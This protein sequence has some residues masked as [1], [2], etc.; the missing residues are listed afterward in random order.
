MNP[1]AC[2][3][4]SRNDKHLTTELQRAGD[5]LDQQ[6]TRAL[7]QLDPSVLRTRLEPNMEDLNPS[8]Q[9]HKHITFDPIQTSPKRSRAAAGMALALVAGVVGTSA[10]FLTFGKDS[11]KPKTT[12]V[13]QVATTQTELQYLNATYLPADFCL[14]YANVQ[15]PGE[16]EG[17]SVEPFL[18]KGDKDGAISIQVMSAM[19][20]G[21][22]PSLTGENVDINGNVGSLSGKA[23]NL[24]L[25][26]KRGKTS[27]SMQARDVAKEPLLAIARSIALR[28]DEN[29][30]QI[31]SISAAGFTQQAPEDPTKRTG[32]YANWG[33]CGATFGPD[34]FPNVNLSVGRP[35]PL[36]DDFSFGPGNADVEESVYPI[37]RNGKPI[38]A[39]KTVTDY[40]GRKNTSV[41]WSENDTAVFVGV[42][43]VD[44]I[45]LGKI[46]AGLKTVSKADFK[47]LA[48]TAKP[49]TGPGMDGNNF[50]SDGPNKMQDLDVFTE[51][52]TEITIQAAVKDG[53]LCPSIRAGSGSSGANCMSAV[54]KPKFQMNMSSNNY[55]LSLA[56]SDETVVKAQMV[57][58]D[59]TNKEIRSVIDPRLPKI[60][61]FVLYRKLADP[62]PLKIQFLDASGKVVSEQ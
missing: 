52:T 28:F 46:I 27:V 34:E 25:S 26:W 20:G 55:S 48:K 30:A 51:G 31:G 42:S 23:P 29:G 62:T 7:P 18:L 61:L 60:R 1:L 45:E 3:G 2:L 6:F 39:K 8:A 17:Y 22:P 49:P 24:M 37:E 21:M 4:Q 53:K 43:K 50:P 54:V 15:E 11:N 59:G 12:D 44:D 9:N 33:K 40:Q 13:A 38:T 58:A 14:F 41:S 19:M 36:G 47:K 5:A 56:A 35:N 16:D 10:A 57:F 32:G